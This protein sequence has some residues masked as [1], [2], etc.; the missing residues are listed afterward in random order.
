MSTRLPDLA[1]A[2]DA[3]DAELN[4]LQNADERPVSYAIEPPAGTPRYG[5]AYRAH[6]V[7][8][9]NARQKRYVGELGLDR[10]PASNCSPIAACWET[11]PTRR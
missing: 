9:R 1:E 10:A 11:F 6:R 2:A 3:V 4:Y 7:R 8:I 5:G